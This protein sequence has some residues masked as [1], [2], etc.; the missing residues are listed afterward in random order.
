MADRVGR[1]IGRASA[2]DF[3]KFRVHWQLPGQEA[4]ARAGPV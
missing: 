1:L 4:H 3:G 2:Q